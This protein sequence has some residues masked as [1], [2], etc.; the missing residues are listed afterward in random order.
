MKEAI[1]LSES[2]K[3]KIR[4][5]K[6]ENQ[7]NI[8]YSQ[9][10]VYE[11]CP[12]RW[13]LSYAKGH[14]LFS[15]SINTVFGTAIHEAV[16]EYLRIIFQETVKKADSF[17]MIG[18]FEKRFK[19]EYLSEMSNNGDKHFSTKEE[20]VEFYEDGVEI[21]EHF[22]R[23]RSLYFSKRDHE[24]IGMEIPLSVEIKEDDDTFL[25]NG[26]IDLV[27]KDKRDGV[28]YIEDFKTSTKGWS[29]Y[30][31]SDEIKQSQILL[32]KKYFSKQ[33]G[34]DI[35]TI[36]PKYRILKRKLW[37]NAEFA[38]S[39]I[40]IHEPANGTRKVKNAEQR[41]NVFIN[42]CFN[43]DGTPKEGVYTKRASDQNCKFCPFNDKR[44][45]C[46]KNKSR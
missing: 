28:V 8:S 15:A 16:Q 2:I 41:L 23:K 21:L 37:E 46:D 19:E 11:Q 34:V 18:F 30:E 39:R 24:L 3:A 9:Y 14:Y 35:D 33:F 32:Y 40:Q 4:K 26:Y 31:K 45:F 17:D 36:V 27:Y 43:S 25:F 6:R 29:K 22:R 1:G 20:M 7:K 42:E 5:E 12:H 38:Q 44:D 10:S 13:Y